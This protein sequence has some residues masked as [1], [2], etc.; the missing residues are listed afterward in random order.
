M[1]QICGT[2]LALAA[3]ALAAL[4]SPI[5]A[6]ATL[7]EMDWGY[8]WGQGD[9][10]F[11]DSVQDSNP[12]PNRGEYLGSILSY[13]LLGWIDTS[14]KFVQLSGS[15]GS[16][17]VVNH[18]PAIPGCVTEFGGECPGELAALTVHLGSAAPPYDPAGWHLSLSV[19]WNLGNFFDSLPAAGF[20]NTLSPGE[21]REFSR[22]ELTGWLETNNGQVSASS[23][24]GG[25]P[26][27]TLMALAVPVPEPGTIPLL[28]L[29]L[30]MLALR[31]G[32]RKKDRKFNAPT[33]DIAV[34]FAHVK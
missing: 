1:K 5:S 11:D 22:Y 3:V 21:C 16:M 15:A 2:R 30:A 17:S 31:I 10:V 27:V 12:D 32:K 8:K 13:T 34:R 20:C 7:Y 14:M 29:G 19:P 33:G 6:N 24:F 25:Y 9:I 4:L 28:G 23:I 18:G 26:S